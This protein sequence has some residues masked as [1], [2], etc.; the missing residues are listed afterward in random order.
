MN[1]TFDENR[2]KFSQAAHMAA[3][4]DVYPG[5]FPSGVKFLDV[6]KTKSDLDYAVD[7]E[8]QIYSPDPLVRTSFRMLIQERWRLPKSQDWRDMTIT[9]WNLASN[10]PS[11]LY[12]L[13]AG[14][15]VYGYYNSGTDEIVRAFGVSVPT[16]L[17]A[18]ARGITQ[19]KERRPRGDQ[20]FNAFDWD[21]S[22][23]IR[24]TLLRWPQ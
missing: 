19:F 6:T 11:E 7:C 15:F 10:T 16:L 5:W 18:N 13:A 9:E 12:K 1:T 22:E 2:F 21:E 3:E 17:I 14:L 23:R 24:A 20:T 8:A 4:R